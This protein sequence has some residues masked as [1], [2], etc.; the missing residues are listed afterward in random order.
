MPLGFRE[1]YTGSRVSENYYFSVTRGP[2]LLQETERGRLW[3]IT[4]PPSIY[5]ESGKLHVYTTKDV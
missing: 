2:A 4:G 3:Q 1:P 5:R